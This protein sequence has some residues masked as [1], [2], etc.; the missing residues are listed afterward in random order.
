MPGKI[1]RLARSIS[2]AQ[3]RP[4]DAWAAA[5]LNG[6]ELRVYRGMDPRDR[7][8]GLRVARALLAACPQAR[9]EL[10]AA[11]ILHDCGKSIRTYRVWERVAVGLVPYRVG[12]ALPWQPLELRFN[13]PE[14][15]AGLVRAAG[16]REEVAR[17]I[18]RHHAPAGD[19]EAELLYRFDHLE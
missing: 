8:H 15:G 12:H 11:A 3:A 2:A 17:L 4:D 13:H 18:E 19:P 14:V 16:G 5:R 7:E 10:V 6:G 1:A 9:P